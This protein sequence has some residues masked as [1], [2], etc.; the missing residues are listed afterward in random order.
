MHLIIDG[1]N[2]LHVGHSLASITA[3][4]L[5]GRRDRLIEQL[6]SYRHTKPC[7]ITVVFDGWQGGWVT[8]KKE[9]RKGIDVIFSRLRE[10]AD[11]VVK[12]LAKEKGAGA[13]VVT[14]DR[15]IASYA[16]RLAVAVIPSE[17]F[18]EKLERSVSLGHQGIAQDGAEETRPG[19]K[20]KGPSRRLS[21]KERRRQAALKKL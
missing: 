5:E 6:S 9:K 17:V 16:E 10:R 3:F 4:E 21:K 8:E 11:E 20:K 14:S 15:E 19:E 13:V 2:L 12:R 18:R 1:Y 7:D